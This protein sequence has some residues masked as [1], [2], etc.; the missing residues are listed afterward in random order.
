MGREFQKTFRI[1]NVLRLKGGEGV[2]LQFGYSNIAVKFD[3]N[4]GKLAGTVIIFDGE[5]GDEKVFYVY[6]ADNCEVIEYSKRPLTSEELLF[7]KEA[8][9]SY[10]EKHAKKVEF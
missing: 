5:W 6:G 9:L 4:E 2:E 8:V 1:E 10:C 3:E 7:V